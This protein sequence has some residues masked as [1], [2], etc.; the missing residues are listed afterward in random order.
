VDLAAQQ[1]LTPTQLSLAFVYRRWC[2]GSTIIGATSMAQLQENLDA[3]DV[4]LSS[5]VLQAIERI[6]LEYPNPAP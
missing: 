3:S 6:H 1:G 5:E 4:T 2:V